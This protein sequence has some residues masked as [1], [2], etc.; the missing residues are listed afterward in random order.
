MR[1]PW[2]VNP[3]INPVTLPSTRKF[4]SPGRELC[5]QWSIKLGTPQGIRRLL[6]PVRLKHTSSSA[7]CL[8]NQLQPNPHQIKEDQ[9][10]CGRDNTTRLFRISW[11]MWTRE[12]R[13]LAD[14][15]KLKTANRSP[16][17]QW[18]VGKLERHEA[19]H[20]TKM[21]ILNGK[22]YPWWLY[23]KCLTA[24]HLPH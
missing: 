6:R 20:S 18:S 5:R 8:N 3:L 9:T 7:S 23:T 2:T 15:Q 14:E 10:R 13:F 24:K 4:P 11:N 12:S 22:R 19:V 1:R 21:C 16:W 17:R